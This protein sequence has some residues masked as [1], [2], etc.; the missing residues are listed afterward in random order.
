MRCSKRLVAQPRTSARGACRGTF[1]WPYRYARRRKIQPWRFGSRPGLTKLCQMSKSF[2]SKMLAGALTVLLVGQP[3]LMLSAGPVLANSDAAEVTAEPSKDGLAIAQADTP[4]AAGAEGDTAAAAE[5]ELDSV[6][7]STEAAEADLDSTT[8]ETAR[9]GTSR[10]LPTTGCARTLQAQ[11]DAAPAGS[12]LTPLVCVYRETATVNKPLVLSAA[13]G[14]EIRGSDVWTGW[15]KRGAYWV[16]GPLPAMT[17][18]GTC[19]AG[20]DSCHWREQI[21]YGGRPLLHVASNPTSGQFALDASRNVL[22]ADD[23]TQHLVEVSTRTSWITGQSDNV[24]IEGWRM[25]HAANDAQTGALSPGGYSNWTIQ[26]NVLSDA[27]GADVEIARGTGHRLLRNDISRGGQLGVMGGTGLVQANRIHDNNVAGFDAGWEAGGLK[28]AATAGATWDANEVDHNQGPGLW[29]DLHCQN[30]TISNNRTHHNLNAGIFFEISTGATIVGNAVW[31][32]GWGFRGWGWGGGI[33]LSSSA[34][35]EVARN[36]VAWNA[37]GI[38][39]ISQN[40]PDGIATRGQDVHDNIIASRDDPSDTD[41]NL[42]LGWLQDWSG[43]MF[44]ASSNNHGQSNA[45]WYPAPEPGY[46]RFGWNGPLTRMDDLNSTP[47]GGGNSRYLTVS[48]KD[49]LLTAA[50]VPLAPEPR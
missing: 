4:T 29:C 21:F 18:S 47:A 34:G 45:F 17:G 32:N 42:S 35:V 24:T 30:I 15:T 48:E 11:I 12:T 2:V 26:D 37:D 27:H 46:T 49:Q 10:T 9:I 8:F 36:V 1:G 28:A 38:T 50:Q 19:Q 13:P 44:D 33:L 5:A 6:D 23:P 43:G 7:Q 39:V 22:L 16:K 41:S 14:T 31:E 3:G 20:G 25:R 40:R